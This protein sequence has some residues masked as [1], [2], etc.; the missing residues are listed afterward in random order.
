MPVNG[1]ECPDCGHVWTEHNTIVGCLA[2]W[3]YSEE[4]V[5][6]NQGCECELAHTQRSD[7]SER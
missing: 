2:D 6:M 4:G 1:D 7:R 3:V 5:A